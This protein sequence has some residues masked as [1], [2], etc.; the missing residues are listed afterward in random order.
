MACGNHAVLCV[1][2]LSVIK[3][4]RCSYMELSSTYEF[5][6]NMP[7]CSHTLLKVG[8]FISTCT[9][10]ISWLILV[11]FD[12]GNV[13]MMPVRICELHEN[14]CSESHT[15]LKGV[16]WI[17]S[18][19]LHFSHKLVYFSTVD[20]LI[21]LLHDCGYHVN[22]HTESYTLFFYDIWC[23]RAV[24]WAFVGVLETGSSRAEPVTRVPMKLCLHVYH[25]TVWYFESKECYVR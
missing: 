7:S 21:I 10:D 20:V 17:V 25:E 11:K 24:H 2:L 6:G 3:P 15:L 9:F 5:G 4:A 1:C 14:Q 13:G 23:V 8:K 12:V 19:F 18:V 22:W 16:N